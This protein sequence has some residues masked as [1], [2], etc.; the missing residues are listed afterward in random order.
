MPAKAYAPGQHIPLRDH[1]PADLHIAPDLAGRRLH[2]KSAGGLHMHIPPDPADILLRRGIQQPPQIDSIR[3]VI[4]PE[5]AGG[6]RRTVG[7]N[8]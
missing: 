6:C 1:T 3:H 8:A 4:L 5:R 7:F 2:D